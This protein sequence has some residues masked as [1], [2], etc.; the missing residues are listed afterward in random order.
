MLLKDDFCFE[1]RTTGGGDTTDNMGDKILEHVNRKR[2]EESKRFFLF[3]GRALLY[4]LY[5]L[6]K[7]LAIIVFKVYSDLKSEYIC[8]KEKK[9]KENFTFVGSPEGSG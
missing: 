7:V 1:I 6:N 2:S 4:Y 5:K 8:K 9:R 3:I